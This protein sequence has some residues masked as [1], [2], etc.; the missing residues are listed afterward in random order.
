M[1]DCFVNRENLQHA[2][3]LPSG[4]KLIDCDQMVTAVWF[5]S[6]G[7]TKVS[8]PNGSILRINAPTVFGEVAFLTGAKAMADVELLTEA[9]AVKIA[10]DELRAWAA[11]DSTRSMWLYENLTKIASQRLSGNYH[12]R[13]LALVAHDGRKDELLAFI[14]EHKA[15]FSGQNLLATAST[16]QRIRSELGMEIA[17]IVLS[18]PKGGDQEIGGLISR[19]AVDALFFFR[20][21]LWAQPHQADVNA[22]VRICEVANV[23]LATNTRTA[24]LIVDGLVREQERASTL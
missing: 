24:A 15:F 7:S 2:V 23:P 17:R 4:T 9:V 1:V 11:Q 21:P 19:G 8:M 20:D 6:E 5:I 3:A 13:Y 12:R 16:G 14:Q 10:C 18:G 22:L